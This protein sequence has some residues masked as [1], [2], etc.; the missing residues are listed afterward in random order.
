MFVHCKFSQLKIQVR[1]NL[2]LTEN[3]VI[4]FSVTDCYF[5][6]FPQLYV[7]CK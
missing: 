4:Q 1:D 7:T 5:D 3:S 2:N 6:P